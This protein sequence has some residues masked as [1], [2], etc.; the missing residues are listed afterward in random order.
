[1]RLFAARF[2]IENVEITPANSLQ[3]FFLESVDVYKLADISRRQFFD[4]VLPTFEKIAR[5]SNG[6]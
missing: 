4:K 1:M 2:S 3:E 6:G 5:R